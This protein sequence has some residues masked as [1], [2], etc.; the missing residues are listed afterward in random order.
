MKLIGVLLLFTFLIGCSI[1]EESTQNKELTIA[2]AASL[3]DAL[4][5]VKANY[6]EK[7]KTQ[8]NYSFGSSGSLQEQI[9]QGAP[10]D[11]FFSAAEDKFNTLVKE[12]KIDE[13]ETAHILT[14]E[15]V[16]IV[17]KN[18]GKPVKTFED[19]I[20]TSRIAVGIPESVPAG[21]YAKE[22]LESLGLW[23]T[24]EDKLVFGKDVRQVLTYVET[25]NVDA[26]IVYKS[27]A[28]LSEEVEVVATAKVGSHTPIVYPLGMISDSKNKE[29]AK[30]F[31]QYL[32]SEEAIDIFKKYGFGTY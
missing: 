20:Q 7:Y 12:G 22:S 17:P 29:E 25:N 11:L 28:F 31:F 8:I 16:L 32:Q 4:Q 14:N 6:E 18:S 1:N 24:L 10:V 9:T 2:A 19:L 3:A 30:R 23:S 13:T 21:K 27:D 15:L 26:G 5:E